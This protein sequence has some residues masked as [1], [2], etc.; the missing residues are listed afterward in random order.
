[1]RKKFSLHIKK[2]FLKKYFLLFLIFI[3]HTSFSQTEI[4][5][6][7][8]EILGADEYEY[9]DLGA[10]K[11]KTLTGNVRLQQEDVFLFC[12]K[13]V[14]D[15][16]ANSLN[17]DGHVKIEQ[18]TV[19]IHSDHLFY[20]GDKRKALLTGNVVMSDSKMVLKTSSLDYDLKT[21]IG[22][23]KTGGVLTSDSTTLTS[24]IGYYYAETN[25]V[26]FK[27]E[28]EVTSPNYHLSAD[29]LR[30]NTDSRTAFFL[31]PTNIQTDSADVFCE[32]GF[33]DTKNDI[34][35][36]TTKAIMI[37]YPNVLSGDSI[38]FDNKSGKG[39][40]A[41]SI[42]WKDTAQHICI[43]AGNAQYEKSAQE[44]F[45]TNHPLFISEADDD[46]LFLAA[47]VL[48]S[49][50]D[51]VSHKRSFSAYHHVKIY[52]SDM[53]GVCDSLFYSEK[54]S[55]FRLYQHPVLWLDENQLKADTVRIQMSNREVK[56]FYLIKSSFMASE[57]DE[58]LFNQAKGK[59]IT[60]FFSDGKLS[61]MLIEGNGESIYYAADDS[62][63]FIGVNKIACTNMI[64]Y[65]DSNRVRKIKFISKPDGNMY[66]INQ[67]PQDELR[68]K[69]FQWLDAERPKS[70]WELRK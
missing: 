54:D 29:T 51:S 33:Y 26:Y 45:A 27:K 41:G 3:S 4:H 14:L 2:L 40:A 1:M 68:L 31:G 25:D 60:G 10:Q 30:F 63:A 38:W 61:H 28:V 69:D 37:N 49:T 57:A 58:N 23:Y 21:K 46:S 67:A 36:F 13:A 16:E 53:Q 8:I 52:K 35:Q 66:P 65:V 50:E 32:G 6:T 17:A 56:N 7:K 62:G 18:D 9:T 20:D 24:Q 64:I 15:D 43:L 34:A 19:T 70:Q 39:R 22:S 48:H 5:G 55:M 59:N 12:D 47:D 44:I 42:V 11:L